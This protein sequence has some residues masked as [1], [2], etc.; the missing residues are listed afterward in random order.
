MYSDLERSLTTGKQ[1]LP[2][3]AMEYGILATVV[4]QLEMHQ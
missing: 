3:V 2:V 1:E 4:D